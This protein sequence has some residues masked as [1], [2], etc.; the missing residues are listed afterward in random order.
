MING[1]FF[2]ETSLQKRT[3]T[4]HRLGYQ[5]KFKNTNYLFKNVSNAH[6][7]EGYSF[8]LVRTLAGNWM[9]D[10]LLVLL[11]FAVSECRAVA[12]AQES[13]WVKAFILMLAALNYIATRGLP[14]FSHLQL[15]SSLLL[16]THPIIPLVSMR[17]SWCYNCETFWD[18]RGF[19]HVGILYAHTKEDS[20]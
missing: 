11:P 12:V 3:R 9:R 6:H 10:I 1:H 2:I 17:L 15:W 4:R 7:R 8:F 19:Y 14:Y 18:Q 13:S 16:S 20:Y 5:I